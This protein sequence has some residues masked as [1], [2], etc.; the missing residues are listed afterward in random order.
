MTKWLQF[1]AASS[2]FLLLAGA[3]FLLDGTWRD[4]R[5]YVETTTWP[6]VQARVVRC[7]VS[8]SW[9]YGGTPASRNIMGE[10][11]YVRCTFAYDADGSARENTI[12]VG[13]TVF[14][15]PWRKPWR[16]PF[17]PAVTVADMRAWI[18]RHPPGSVLTMH[19]D[20][21]DSNRISIADADAELRTD[22]PKGRFQIGTVSTTL[23]IT[24]LALTRLA[25]KRL[26][27]S[28]PGS[29]NG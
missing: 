13:N 8:G 2:G 5:Q 11:S 23:G 25:R 17:G 21:S 10:S 19:H 7:S 22:S 26:A 27:T 6:S 24:L 14:S 4:Y 1:V 16:K 15:S 9:H 12:N 18:A 20:P 29:M 28:A 3:M